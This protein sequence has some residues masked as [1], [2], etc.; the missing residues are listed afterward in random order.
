MQTLAS[1]PSRKSINPFLSNTSDPSTGIA[2]IDG[3]PSKN[4]GDGDGLT[5]I[6]AGGAANGGPPDKGPEEI[7]K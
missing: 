4:D 6:P 3:S 2:P 5:Q 1:S 7:P